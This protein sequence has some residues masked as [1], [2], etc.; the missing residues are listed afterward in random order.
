MATTRTDGA[1]ADGELEIAE[2]V[3][4]DQEAKP[5]AATKPEEAGKKAAKDDKAAIP[6]D[7]GIEE[8]RKQLEEERARAAQERTARLEAEKRAF[9]TAKTLHRA[10]NEV[11]DSH[12][13]MV[14][15][16]IETV[17]GNLDQLEAA[18]AHASSQG[19]HASIAKIQRAIAAATVELR[20]LEDGKK[21]LASR[22]K[23]P[24]P[25]ISDP[26]EA[27]AA[28]LT[29]RSAEW[30]RRHPEFATDPVLNRKMV[31]AHNDAVANGIV[32]DTDEYF[33]DVEATLQR[34]GALRSVSRGSEDNGEDP[35]S[36]A[37]SPAQRRSSP[38]AAPVSRQ[39]SSSSSVQSGRS[40]R[41]SEAQRAAA[42]A[43]GLTEEQYA[44]N[45]DALRREGRLN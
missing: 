4:L 8:L 45:I 29:P 38:A 9:E 42:A 10:Q 32:P 13:S 30:V 12:L 34:R 37:S 39:G 14:E 2:L 11:A 1:P 20:Q 44:R 22:P 6:A 43:S 27:L 18:M 21:D 40:I 16:A 35:F 19:D 23:T 28:Q 41:L 5:D 25:T 7:I 24:E 26:V 31:A 33:E 3:K 17:K 36:S 15:G